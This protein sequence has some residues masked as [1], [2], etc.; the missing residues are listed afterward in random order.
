MCGNYGE[1][2]QKAVKFNSYFLGYRTEPPIHRI[3]GFIRNINI[4][5]FVG[6]F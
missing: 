6:C 3:K 4:V 5:A 2:K 1:E